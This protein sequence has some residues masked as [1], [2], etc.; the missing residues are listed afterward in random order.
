MAC[1]PPASPDALAG[2]AP[3]LHDD[4]PGNVCF[5]WQRGDAAEAK[6]WGCAIR[7]SRWKLVNMEKEKSWQLFD[8]KNDPGEK[9]NQAAAQPAVMEQLAAE[10][11]KWWTSVQPQLV[12]EAAVIP[13]ENAFRTLYRQQ[14]GEK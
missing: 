14:F 6:Y 11:E 5:R 1:P 4:A 12:N 2:G 3:R 7:N 8:L 9:Q 10:Y 13:A